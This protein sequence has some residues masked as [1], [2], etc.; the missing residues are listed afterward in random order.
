MFLCDVEWVL[1]R[2]RAEQ[3]RY[4]DGRVATG[5]GDLTHFM[6]FSAS[7]CVVVQDPL[8]PAF[9]GTLQCYSV[10]GFG[11]ADTWEIRVSGQ[12][13]LLHSQPGFAYARPSISSLDG[14]G[15]VQASTHGNQTVV[16]L[17]TQFGTVAHNAITYV[18]YGP[19][20]KYTAQ[21]C[22]VTVDHVRMECEVVAGAGSQLRWSV[23]VG[24]QSS[25]TP[26][27][28]YR[29]PVVYNI[30]GPGAADANTEGG[31]TVYIAGDHFG[32]IAE[33]L[34][35][36]VTYGVYSGTVPQGSLYVAEN[37]TV[38]VDH[39]LI[40][41]RTAAGVGF[42][43][44]WI[45]TISGQASP[46][47]TVRTSYGIPVIYS[48]Y[49]ATGSPDEVAS[50]DADG[51]S[52]VNIA[53]LNFGRAGDARVVF[54]GQKLDT[55]VYLNHR[56]LQVCDCSTVHVGVRLAPRRSY[57]EWNAC[58]LLPS[59]Q[60][61]AVICAAVRAAQFTAP[62]GSGSNVTLQVAVGTRFSPPFRLTYSN[63][64]FS[65]LN[66]VRLV[67]GLKNETVVLQ[68]QGSS[69]GFACSSCIQDG[70]VSALP[71]C[72]TTPPAPRIATLCSKLA[73]G[74]LAPPVRAPCIFFGKEAECLHLRLLNIT[75]VSLCKSLDAP[76]VHPCCPCV[77]DL[78]LRSLAFR[79]R[80]AA[81]GA[82][83]CACQMRRAPT[84]ILP[85]GLKFLLPSGASLFLLPVWCPSQPCT[86]TRS[87]PAHTSPTPSWLRQLGFT[88]T[89]LCNVPDPVS[90]CPASHFVGAATLPH[91]P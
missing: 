55:T 44:Q 4:W 2:L 84:A 45:V 41:C 64:T 78:W 19:D 68:L 40:E 9:N 63:P 47:S 83:P 87:V 22:R 69:F 32:T 91:H 74:S 77:W 82:L 18:K 11:S 75:V 25:E 43:L 13:G 90:S 70:N 8:G 15:A 27:T 24:N 73:C 21:N 38:V 72:V 46:L 88:K 89:V 42:N 86:T 80:R 31:D 35:D 26:T 23:S 57:L 1:A 66:Y 54:S 67:S 10:P 30:T 61:A 12:V 49:L 28:S 81:Q 52:L 36:L 37:C 14:P 56:A 39:V 3:V 51:S 20:N 85:A 7:R 79:T 6:S 71:V 53:G 5:N 48:A 33:S 76:V 62:S 50:L 65:L 60:L 34:V 16:I 29:P 59:P 17:G 58:S